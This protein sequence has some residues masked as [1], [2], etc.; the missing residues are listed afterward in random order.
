M[1]TS[2]ASILFHCP[3]CNENFEFDSIGENEFVPC[4]VCGTEFVTTRKG[5]KVMLEALEQ[6]LIC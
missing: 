4:P 3:Q 2:T 1:K 6:A 5:G